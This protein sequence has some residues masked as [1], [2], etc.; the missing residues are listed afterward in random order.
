MLMLL[1]WSAETLHSKPW[2]NKT[3]IS[4]LFFN[5]RIKSRITFCNSLFVSE[6][7]QTFSSSLLFNILTLIALMLASNRKVNIFGYVAMVFCK[8]YNEN[9]VSIVGNTLL[10]VQWSS[11]QTEL[12]SAPAL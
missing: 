7:S 4:F 2:S 12:Q 11:V 10:K 5:L 3:W 6:S 9:S 8:F 1:I